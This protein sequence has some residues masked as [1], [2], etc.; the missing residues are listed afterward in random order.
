[1]SRR[2]KKTIFDEL[3]DNVSGEINEKL[4]GIGGPTMVLESFINEGGF[5][6]KLDTNKIIEMFNNAL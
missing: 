3:I 5:A 1:M 2:H 6:N 4:M